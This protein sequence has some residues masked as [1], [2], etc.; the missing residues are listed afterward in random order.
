MRD[1]LVNKMIRPLLVVVL[2]VNSGGMI[3]PD[4]SSS[5]RPAAWLTAGAVMMNNNSGDQTKISDRS[6]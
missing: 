5:Q 3:H 1:F 2:N 6:E 4:R